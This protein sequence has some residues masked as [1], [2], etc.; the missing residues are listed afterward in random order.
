MIT[1]FNKHK[2]YKHK[3]NIDVAFLVTDIN[4]DFHDE[5]HLRGYWMRITGMGTLSQE[6]ADSITVKHNDI[7]NWFIYNDSKEEAYE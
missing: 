7:S 6:W 5:V 4:A 3:N 1:E 2:I